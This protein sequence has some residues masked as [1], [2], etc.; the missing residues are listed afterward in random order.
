MSSSGVGGDDNFRILVKAFGEEVAK[1]IVAGMSTAS[2]GGEDANYKKAVLNFIKFQQ[3]GLT[4]EHKLDEEAARARG[5]MMN[6]MKRAEL[7][8]QKAGGLPNI[9]ALLSGQGG[10]SVTGGLGRL[11]KMGEKPFSN[12]FAYQKKMDEFTKTHGGMG[13]YTKQGMKDKAEL[14]IDKSKL[15]NALLGKKM[16]GM[17]GKVGKFMESGAGQGAMGAGMMGAS[18]LTMIIK[19]A[20]QASPMMQAM[21]KIMNTAIM[22]YLRPI[23]DFIG[24]MLRPIALFFMRE[25]AIPALRAGKGM[26]AMGEQMGKGIL[27]FALKPIESIQKAIINGLSKMGLGA[28][29]DPSGY[30]KNYDPIKD[31]MLDK[32]I[33]T[34]IKIMNHSL[35][36]DLVTRDIL[37]D[38]AT[39]GTISGP[40][41]EE[42][43]V[44]INVE[45]GEVIIPAYAS[46]SVKS[47]AAALVKQARAEEYGNA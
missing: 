35:G 42:G 43:G 2:K 20:I 5:V 7:K 45:G 26:M 21:L 41:H 27:G 17:I 16:S 15:P 46:S 31:W 33:D 9:A 39:G 3:R 8:Q 36:A 32:K 40:S 18:I 28:L 6:I 25:V 19:K 30:W 12:V 13:P 1:A 22:L 38:L 44:D 23:G 29:S 4:H 11:Q 24:G 47:K 34:M 10:G 37:E 14:D